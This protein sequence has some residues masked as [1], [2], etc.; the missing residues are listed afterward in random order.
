V[1]SIHVCHIVELQIRD[2]IYRPLNDGDIVLIN[3]PPSIHQ[4]SL[5][6][7]S[8]KVL[9]VTSVLAINPLC[10]SPLRGDF[11]GDCLHGYVPQSIDARVELCELVALDR[12]VINGQN[13]R[14]LLSLSQDSLT[15]AHLVMEDGVLLNLFQMQ[16]PQMFCPYQVQLPAIVKAP[17]L[18][19][20]I[21]TGKQLF[22]MLLPPGFD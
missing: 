5:I 11:D 20:S 6:A 2:T 4:N 21:W 1:F 17:S 16:Q 15:A 19:S 8:V 10:C 22:S 3:R 7:L 13:G 14:N 18:D 9:P 12:Q